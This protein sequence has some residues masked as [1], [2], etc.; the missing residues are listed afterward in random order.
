MKNVKVMRRKKMKNQD[1]HKAK[2]SPSSRSSS[3]AFFSSPK[4]FAIIALGFLLLILVPLSKNYSRKRLIE[5]EIAEISQ[6]IAE[7]ENKN[8]DLQEMI[9]YLQSDQSLEEQARLN[10]GMRRPGE[11]VAVVQGDF[12]DLIE[13]ERERPAPLPNW[14][15]WQKHF[16]N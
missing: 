6:E 2:R 15:K 11:S 7:F 13:L 3:F 16:F 10:M 1:R 4:V 5:R 8:K 14:K 12:L 9:S